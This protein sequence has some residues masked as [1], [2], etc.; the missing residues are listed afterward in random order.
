MLSRCTQRDRKVVVQTSKLGS[1]RKCS[2][3][4]FQHTH[5]HKHTYTHTCTHTHTHMHARTYAHAHP[6][7]HTHSQTTPHSLFNEQN[8]LKDTRNTLPHKASAV[9]RL[10]GR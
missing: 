8:P 3:A 4:V 9:V 6:H 7:A 2:G 1:V 10:Q 5:T